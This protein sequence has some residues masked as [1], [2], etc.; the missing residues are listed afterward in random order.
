MNFI[1]SVATAY[2]LCLF[3]QAGA[4]ANKLC[5][6][7]LAKRISRIAF[8]GDSRFDPGNF[9]LY[10]EALRLARE[11]VL[12]QPV[13]PNQPKL[14]I[15]AF[16]ERVVAALNAKNI[17]VDPVFFCQF[18]VTV[19]SASRSTMFYSDKYGALAPAH[20]PPKAVVN[21]PS[22]DYYGESR[23][24]F[25][26][27]FAANE[28]LAFVDRVDR[29]AAKYRTFL[30]GGIQIFNP[31]DYRHWTYFLLSLLAKSIP[32]NEFLAMNFF[33]VPSVLQRIQ[34]SI[35]F[36]GIYLPNPLT[37]VQSEKIQ[38]AILFI[39]Y[40]TF[41]LLK[42]EPV[43]TDSIKRDILA[44]S[45]LT[46]G[47]IFHEKSFFCKRHLSDLDQGNVDESLLDS[48]KIK[49][50]DIKGAV[51]SSDVVRALLFDRLFSI[52]AV[53]EIF[54]IFKQR[55]LD[56]DTFWRDASLSNGQ[57]IVFLAN[58]VDGAKG[59]RYWN[60]KLVS[61]PSNSLTVTEKA[62]V[63]IAVIFIVVISHRLFRAAVGSL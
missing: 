1:L 10:P 30:G 4:S 60:L 21:T 49:P 8:T 55:F 44:L 59:L 37:A 45:N 9:Y 11:H 40:S 7:S 15:Q 38:M 20:N 58:K 52:G 34:P 46:V 42:Y 2:L 27:I 18:Y 54:E 48:I 29:I 47:N 36:N 6:Q 57:K 56:V 62:L 23:A 39:M 5:F 41:D 13:P 26:E 19:L 28:I 22:N 33:S 16:Y 51:G 31:A 17:L 61:L 50:Q 43:I 53:T 24:L 35:S 63:A 14:L 25:D 12:L 32:E 3:R